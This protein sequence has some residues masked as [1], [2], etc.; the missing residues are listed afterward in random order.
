MKIS[1]DRIMHVRPK[2]A[3]AEDLMES[4]DGRDYGKKCYWLNRGYVVD[5]IL[6]SQNLSKLV[7]I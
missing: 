2:G 6:H 1:D 7:E 4:V 3:N 5:V